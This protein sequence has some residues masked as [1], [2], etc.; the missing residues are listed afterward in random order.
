MSWHK[1]KWGKWRQYNEVGGKGWYQARQCSKC[2]K[3][4]SRRLGT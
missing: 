2:D 3:T 4:Q 1:H